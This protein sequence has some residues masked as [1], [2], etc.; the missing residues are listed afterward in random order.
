MKENMLEIF[1]TVGQF[2]RL[3]DLGVGS[4]HLTWEE[5]V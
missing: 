4:Y 5:R 2:I 1:I 3:S